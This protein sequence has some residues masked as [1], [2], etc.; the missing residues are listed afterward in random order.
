MSNILS[1]N[2]TYI[3]N[4]YTIRV[5]KNGYFEMGVIIV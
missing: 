2:R 5:S 4:T 1:I 3:I